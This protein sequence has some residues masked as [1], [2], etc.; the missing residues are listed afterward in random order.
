[1]NSDLLNSLQKLG[2]SP[3]D[4]YLLTPYA[5]IARFDKIGAR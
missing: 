5:K 1:V 2:D 3:H 4:K